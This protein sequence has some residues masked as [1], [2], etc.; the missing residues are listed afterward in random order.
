MLKLHTCSVNHT[1][2]PAIDRTQRCRFTAGSAAAKGRR[3]RRLRTRRG[4]RRGSWRRSAAPGFGSGRGGLQLGPAQHGSER[5]RAPDCWGHE[6]SPRGRGEANVPLPQTGARTFHSCPLTR[7]PPQ[8]PSP[9]APQPT[10]K[11]H[12]ATS[13][14]PPAISF[15]SYQCSEQER[16]GADPGRH[17]PRPAE[18]APPAAR[19]RRAGSC[20]RPSPARP[21]LRFN[22]LGGNA[23]A[24]CIRLNRPSRIRFC[25]VKARQVPT[26]LRLI[27]QGAA[28]P[29]SAT[30]PGRLPALELEGPV[31]L[32]ERTRAGGPRALRSDA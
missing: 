30:T 9:P 29:S 23:A 5:A 20:G 6:L 1:R 31:L 21:A 32:T 19:R 2:R 13:P 25:L 10:P 8:P 15:L 26:R 22:R 11:P 12:P 27:R 28:Q 3:N 24:F 4:R 16:K 7:S 18:S 17:T 14:L